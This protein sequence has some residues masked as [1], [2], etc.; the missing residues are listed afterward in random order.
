MSNWNETT[1]DE[2]TLKITDG[3]HHSPKEFQGGI[4]MFSV[5][6]MRDQ[7]F[8]YQDAKTISEED[9]QKLIKSGCQ[10]E[11]DD[12]LIAKDG[13]VLKHIFRVKSKPDYVLLSSIAIVRPNKKLIDPSFLVFALKEPATKDL[14]LNNFVGGS[15]VPRIVLKDFKKVDLTIPL[16]PEQNRISEILA[17]LEDKVNLLNRQNYT[18]EQ[19][20]ETLYNV[21]FDEKELTN[22]ISDLISLQNGYAFKSK[23]FKGFGTHRVLKIKNI[24]GGI[25]D[26]ETSDFVSEE[27]ISSIDEKFKIKTG[28]V[29]F[30]MTGAKIGKMG[31]I[32]KT[33]SELWLNQRVGLFKEKYNGSRFLAYLHLK[34]DY[35]KDYIDNAA[36]GS[37]QPN[38]SGTGIE[39]CEFPAISKQEIIDYS[40]QL[41]PLYEKL[42]F[43][44][45][46]IQKLEALRDTLLPKLMNG[47]VRIESNG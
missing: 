2:V 31:I 25:V 6:D 29:L 15:G 38:I 19:I 1:L 26:I 11:I 20:A 5:K 36:T 45:G 22:R 40:S 35:G 4:P 32:P 41:A 39:N 34:S 12:I 27:T 37:A 21:W 16:L 28:D 44:L 8:F 14:I 33:N 17:S 30:A 46:Q 47:E 9:Y 42:I 43:N 7:G 24:S 10:P 23:D 13:S 18:L 3:A